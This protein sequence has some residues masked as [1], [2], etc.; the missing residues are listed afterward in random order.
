MSLLV[1]LVLA[2]LAGAPGVGSSE[3]AE[4][5]TEYVPTETEPFNGRVFTLVDG[6]FVTYPPGVAHTGDKIV[7]V[8]EGKRI[9]TVVPPP[10]TGVSVDPMYVGTKPNGAVRAE[11]GGIHAETAPPG[12]W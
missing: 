4:G 1:L 8:I 5:W 3:S 12:S 2:L 6:E 7:C 11:C 9:E 10:K